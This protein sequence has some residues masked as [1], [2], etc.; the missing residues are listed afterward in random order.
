MWKIKHTIVQLFWNTIKLQFSLCSDHLIQKPLNYILKFWISTWHFTVSWLVLAEVWIDRILVET[1]KSTTLHHHCQ[2]VCM[3]LATMSC[4]SQFCVSWETILKIWHA[5]AALSQPS[6]HKY[7]RPKGLL[8]LLSFRET[9]AV[10]IQ[11]YDFSLPCTRAVH[12]STWPKAPASSPSKWQ[13]ET[14]SFLSL[15][16]SSSPRVYPYLSI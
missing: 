2:K 15:W 10:A 4:F 13:K 9:P 3:V 1:K 6:W 16:I 14:Y 5:R 11:C 8:G 7:P 12:F